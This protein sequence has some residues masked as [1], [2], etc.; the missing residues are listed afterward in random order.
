MKYPRKINIG[1]QEGTCP[2]KCNKCLAFG[3]Y[4]EQE[5][6]VR[7]MSL[8]KA[9][10]LI[11]EISEME[12]IPPIQPSIFTEPFANKDLKEIILYCCN[13]NVP[14]NIITNGILL[15]KAWMD[16][17]I[18]CLDRKSVISFSLDA[19]SQEVYEVVRGK[20][21]LAELESK[22]G[23]LLENR[24]EKGPRINVS[25]VYEEDNYAEKDIFL[26]KWKYRADAVRINVAL[27][28]DRRVPTIYRKE[29]GVNKHDICPFLEET[30]IIDAGGEVRVCP[31]DAFEKT[32]MGNVF[33]EGIM[34]VWNGKRMEEFR[35]KHYNNQ[36]QEG[37]FCFGCEWGNSVYD[38]DRIEETEDFIIKIADYS[39]YY[40]RKQ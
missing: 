22:V 25:Y 32:Y 9:Q 34:A 13:K 28:T 29:N 39:L 15:D 17:L 37:D 16:L 24:A 21:S 6:K 23:Y 20:Y 12:V 38:F 10:K 8:E 1:F 4:A 40:N 18:E 31:V 11:D 30:I 35:K 2:L 7:K 27:D 5:K 33:E 26:E 14:L 36:I 3:Q 19:A